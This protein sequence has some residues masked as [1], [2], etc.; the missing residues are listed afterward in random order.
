MK[1]LE[2]IKLRGAGTGEGLL[3]ELLRSLVKSGQSRE[4]VGIKT[5]RH[6]ALENDLSVHLHWESDRPE[7]NGTELGLRLAR[8][9]K[10]FGLMDHSI[11]IDEEEREKWTATLP[12]PKNLK[13]ALKSVTKNK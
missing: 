13:A 2:V 6:A 10:E 4:L 5:Y 12:K 8:A 7:Q 1:W 3:E 11:W 9:F